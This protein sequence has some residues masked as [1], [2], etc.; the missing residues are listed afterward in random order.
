[1]VEPPARIEGAAGSAYV[2]LPTIVVSTIRGGNERVF[3]VCYVMRR[4]NVR[5]R[6]WQIY[7]R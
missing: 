7:S 3:A 6:G 1:M 5:D 4:S 2:S